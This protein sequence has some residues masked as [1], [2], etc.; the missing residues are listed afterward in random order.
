MLSSLINTRH[1]RLQASSS[2]LVEVRLVYR[3]LSDMPLQG[4]PS[5]WLDA[6]RKRVVIVLQGVPSEPWSLQNLLVKYLATLF[7]LPSRRRLSASKW[8]PS[9]YFTNVCPWMGSWVPFLF[10]VVGKIW[11]TNLYSGANA[12][13]REVFAGS[14]DDAKWD[15]TWRNAYV[16]IC[17]KK[18]MILQVLVLS[19][20][21]PPSPMLTY[22]TLLRSLTSTT[23]CDIL[24]VIIGWLS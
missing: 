18:V 15:T 2:P 19:Q 20:M 23:K 10:L 22:A 9:R 11:Y 5:E 1:D 16:D 8:L 17:I 3:G 13:G 14:S 24:S 6:T 7:C 21:P 4:S 12:R